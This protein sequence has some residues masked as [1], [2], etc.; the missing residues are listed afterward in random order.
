MAQPPGYS[1]GEHHGAQEVA[2]VKQ[3]PPGYIE[4][5]SNAY[6]SAGET[7]AEKSNAAAEASRLVEQPTHFSIHNTGTDSLILLAAGEPRYYIDNTSSL[8]KV[9][10]RKRDA[11]GEIISTGA[12]VRPFT[13]EVVTEYAS[14]RQSG[15]SKTTIT[16]SGKF[17]VV[18]S[19]EVSKRQYEWKT[20]KGVATCYQGKLAIATYDIGTSFDVDAA[21]TSLTHVLLSTAFAIDYFGR[22]TSDRRKR[23]LNAVTGKSMSSTGALLGGSYLR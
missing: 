21:H 13:K 22:M 2:D 10:V 9:I 5:N 6:A 23:A 19:F 7:Y 4:A 20:S 1:Q 8:S 11:S 17:S 14:R 18:W 12:I 3:Q 16:G 15:T